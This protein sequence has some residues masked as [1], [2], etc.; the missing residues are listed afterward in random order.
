MKRT[1]LIIDDDGPIRESLRKV[2]MAEG[3][4]VVMAANAENGLNQFNLGHIDLLLLDLNLPLKSGWEL[5]RR[6]TSLN[7]LLPV[8]IITG[9]E[10][11]YSLA[12]AFGV[13]ALMEKPLNVPLL[14]HNIT[15]LLDEPAQTRHKRLVGLNSYVRY[16]A[17]TV[18]RSAGLRT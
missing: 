11:Q 4:D 6:F 12:S 15:A 2:L 9:Q 13:G 10:N 5:F 7:P 16:A 14:L 8:I 18:G 1:I 3:Y 17:D